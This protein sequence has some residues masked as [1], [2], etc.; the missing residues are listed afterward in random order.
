MNASKFFGVPSGLG[1]AGLPD[2]PSRDDLA[3]QRIS[4]KVQIPERGFETAG[5]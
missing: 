3:D 5:F 2:L 1:H 4:G